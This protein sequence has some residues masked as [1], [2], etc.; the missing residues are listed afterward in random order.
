MRKEEEYF[1]LL[2]KISHNLN[3][4]LNPNEVLSSAM[5]M[6]I[7]LMN[8]ER[9]FITLLEEGKLT[10]PVAKNIDKK[11]IEGGVE[12]SKTLI[13]KVINESIPVVTM[14]ARIDDRF[15][16][17]SSVI[18]FG[19]RSV[20]CV[21]LIIK[22]RT[23]GAIY[24]DNR[25]KTGVFTPK[26][27]ELL[28]SFANHAAIAIDNARLYDSLRK[29]IDEKLA[30]QKQV[31]D[32]EKKSAVLH[33]TNRLR[34][35]LAEY[36]VHDLR[37]PLTSILAGLEILLM[38]IPA[39]ASKNDV[40]TLKMVHSS[41]KYTDT[42]VNSMLAI[43]EMEAGQLRWQK[44]TITLNGLVERIFDCQR[45]LLSQGVILTRTIPSSLRL[46]ADPA[47]VERILMNLVGNAVKF[48]TNGAI[49]V[50]A[51]K[52][53]EADFILISVTDTGP[54][55][56]ETDLEKVFDKFHQVRT[57]KE[58]G[59]RSPSSGLGLTFC[60]LAVELMGGR[61]WVKSKLGVGSTF[62]ITLPGREEK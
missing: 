51:Q 12:I 28:M 20:L 50:K 49:Q 34:E 39:G 37:N 3:S 31:H 52:A 22:D 17:E 58:T 55:I 38:K 6:V 5:L 27:K 41:A 43:Y 19:L 40:D 59:Q 42:L 10:F 21:P 24:V 32:E 47:L 4:S 56:P 61:I 46:V 16:N 45:K 23:I 62:Y 36:I 14:D 7:E 30:L 29:S 15:A 11:N 35:A 18:A 44:E 8:A 26:D 25:A 53:E 9:G 54:G 60:K 1:V 48:T 2:S 57:K 13:N 33:E